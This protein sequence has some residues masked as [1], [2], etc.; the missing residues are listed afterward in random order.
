[1]QVT[2]YLVAQVTFENFFPMRL[3]ST[4]LAVHRSGGL[5]IFLGS[6]EKATA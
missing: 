5:K 3:T 4:R 6:L 1:M 2:L